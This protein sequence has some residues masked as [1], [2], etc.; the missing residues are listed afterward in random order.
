MRKVA[1][2]LCLFLVLSSLVACAASD[3][4][5]TE[6]VE[7]STMTELPTQTVPPETEAPTQPPTEPPTEPT[8]EPPVFSEEIT[9]SGEYVPGDEVMPYVLYTPSSAANSEHV[10]LI[11]FL[12]G[13]GEF[14]I[15]QEGFMAEG[16]PPVMSGWSLEGFHAYVLAPHMTDRWNIGYWYR[17]EALAHVKELIDHLAAEKPID[18]DSIILVGFS[19]GGIGATYFVQEEPEMF[20]KLVVMSAPVAGCRDLSAIA[21]PTIGYSETYV[22]G[23]SFMRAQF[24]WVFGADSVRYYEVS[25]G[26]VP[27]A[28]FNDDAD[29]NGRSDLVEWMLSD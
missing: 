1:L 12:H 14:G 19:A 16:L 10:P 2:L 27:H 28:A 18:R 24:S 6:V 5:P 29:E 21:I 26:M 4:V 20:R 8:T 9:F 25:H 7:L 22:A 23:D 11:V 15:S 13:I 3:S 17:T